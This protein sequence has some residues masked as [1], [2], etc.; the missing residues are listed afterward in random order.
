MCWATRSVRL[1][2]RSAVGGAGDLSSSKVAHQ[3][4]GRHAWVN[5]EQVTM[6]A[7]VFFS[8][9][10]V[11]LEDL[12]EPRIGHG[13]LLV[14]VAGV[15]L[16][17]SDIDKILCEAVPP[18]TVLGHEIVGTVAGVGGGVEDFHIGERIAVAHHVSC[19]S[20]HYCDRGSDSKCSL[21]LST[22][23]YP[24]GFAELVRVPEP[25]VRLAAF[26]IPDDVTYEQAVF[27]EPLGCCVRAIERSRLT[28]GDTILIVGAGSIGL[29]LAQLAKLQDVKVLVSDLLP[30]RLDMA[31]SFGVDI[32][33]N[34]MTD[35]FEGAV[36]EVTSGRGV[37]TVISTMAS[38]AVLEQALSLVR[39]GGLIHF[40]AGKRG[41]L[42]AN[43]DLNELYER[44]VGLITTYS[45][46]PRALREAFRLIVEREI[47]AEGLVSH[48]VPLS[49]VMKGVRLMAGQEARKVFIDVQSG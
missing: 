13:E 28:P 39:D 47:R 30:D 24:G 5:G 7:A 2:L 27:T 49:E 3:S 11:H 14:R 1:A 8:S 16:C 41:G 17:G 9:K 4:W 37:D 42:K 31:R 36:R 35:L 29:L 46:S 19:Q 25:N 43:M 12:P 32:A 45:S 38:Q 22:N 44:E 10:D 20:C 15:G 21:F 26:S 40:F 6:K 34:P 33:L 23:L 18:G 48:H